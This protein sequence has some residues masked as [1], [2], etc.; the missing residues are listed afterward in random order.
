MANF[1][2]LKK[3]QNKFGCTLFAEL[4]GPRIA[5]QIF[6]LFLNTPKNPYLNQAT[7]KNTL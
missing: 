5:P 3:L 2:A 4:R 6:R 7:P 1:Q